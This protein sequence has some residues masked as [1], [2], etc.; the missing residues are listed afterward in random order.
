MAKLEMLLIFNGCTK[1][2]SIA[3]LYKLA[4]GGVHVC[5]PKANGWGLLYIEACLYVGVMLVA[6]LFL[7]ISNKNDRDFKQG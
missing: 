3:I 7:C 5:T 6:T 4:N 1:T 2:S